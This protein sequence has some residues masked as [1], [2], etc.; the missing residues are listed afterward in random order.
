MLHLRLSAGSAEGIRLQSLA[1]HASGSG[2]D[3]VELGT[4]ALWRDADGNG[5]VDAGDVSAGTGAFAMDDGS[6][7]FDLSAEPVIPAGGTAL[8]LAAV[9]LK[10]GALSGSTFSFTT[11]PAG[12]VSAKG[13]STS[14]PVTPSGGAVAGGPVTVATSGAGSLTLLPGPNGPAASTVAAPAQGVALLQAILTASS[15]EAVQVSR[16]RVSATGTG[17]DARILRASLIV[18]VD[19]NGRISAGETALAT[20]SFSTD[21]GTADFGPLALNV[22][23]GGRLVLLVAVD[24]GP[25]RSA[26]TYALSVATAPDVSA[27]GAVSGMGILATGAPVQG[28]PITVGS[29]LEMEPVYFF[30]GC[31]GGA[32]AD[33]AGAG[34][35]LLAAAALAALS[36]TRRVARR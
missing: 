24:F 10:A 30:G 23:A 14:T 12:D 7:S 31:G 16:V 33:A 26:G 3:A 32:G 8:Y 1:V 5:L 15:L 4:V 34:W 6:V 19:E 29:G 11:A 28:N 35:V 2:N 18:D 20:A 25:E 36:A 27:T 9:S 22:A 17:D 21:D 13:S